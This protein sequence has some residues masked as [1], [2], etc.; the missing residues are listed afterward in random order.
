MGTKKKYPEPYR[1]SESKTYYFMFS[2]N[3]G[4]RHRMSTG[5]SSKEKAR[6]KI[7][8]LLDDLRSESTSL[9]FAE[10]AAPYFL[11]ESCTHSIRLK[12][13]GESIGL[14]HRGQ[15]RSLLCRHVLQDPVFPRLAIAKIQAAT[16]PTPTAA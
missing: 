7:R 2:G 16:T 15:C 12:Q 14:T 13:E 5:E 6:E 10:Y 8:D 11:P 3:D 9:T 1:R 4:K